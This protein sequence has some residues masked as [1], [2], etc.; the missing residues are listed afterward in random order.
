MPVT[1]A[2]AQSAVF[3]RVDTRV[4]RGEGRGRDEGGHGANVGSPERSIVAKFDK[5]HSKTERERERE[6]EAGYWKGKGEDER[7]GE[8]EGESMDWIVVD[9]A[10]APN[11]AS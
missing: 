5:T 9:V 6:R 10:T 3:D 1:S 2:R 4:E 8:G 11:G 7:G